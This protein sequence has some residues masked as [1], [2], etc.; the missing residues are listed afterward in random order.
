MTY[1]NDWWF[2]AFFQ[3]KTFK[4]YLLLK[5]QGK[6]NY[7]RVL[8]W[9]YAESL[10]IKLLYLDKVLICLKSLTP[11][12]EYSLEIVQLISWYFKTA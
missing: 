2:F 3:A 10:E 11:K 6:G 5:L 8:A 9:K 1:I 7:T 4:V 12:A